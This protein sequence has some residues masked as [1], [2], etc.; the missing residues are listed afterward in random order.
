MSPVLKKSIAVAFAVLI[1]FTAYYGSYL[2]MEKSV[3]FIEAMQD[4]RNIKTI[5]D[6]EKIFSVP[7]DYPSPIGQ[8]E[9]V[10]SIANTVVG[11]LN[12]IADPRGVDELVRYIEGYF[13]PIVS[14]NKGM[15]FGQ[16][17]YML[18]ALNELAFVKTRRPSYL[19]AAEQYFKEAVALGPK[20]P[21]GLYGLFDVYRLKGDVAGSQAVGEQ[22]LQQWPDDE[23]ILQVFSKPV[24]STSSTAR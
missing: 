16:D 19:S 11:N 5:L 14:R 6:F 9:F 17:L 3:T 10:R 20:R 2:P 13:G 12:Y 21:Q 23:K 1:L 8:E 22:I 4:A 15:S 24:V 7:L 18:G